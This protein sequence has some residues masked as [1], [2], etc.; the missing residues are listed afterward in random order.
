MSLLTIGIIVYFSYY[1]IKEIVSM[2][3]KVKTF[4]E[5]FKAGIIAAT[6]IFENMKYKLTLNAAE[7]STTV[8][9]YIEGK[10]FHK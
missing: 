2:Y 9:L 5:G 4:D 8:T 3:S 7:N 1:I 6:P 10:I